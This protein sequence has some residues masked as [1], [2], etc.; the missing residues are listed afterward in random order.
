MCSRTN[1]II[2]PHHALCNHTHAGTHRRVGKNKREH[3]PKTKLEY[4]SSVSN[5]SDC[6]EFSSEN[7]E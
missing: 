7:E 3:E 2:P 5:T 1:E 4:D 6:D